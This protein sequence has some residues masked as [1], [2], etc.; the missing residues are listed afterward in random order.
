[1]S[2]LIGPGVSGECRIQCGMHINEDHFYPR[3]ST[4]KPCEARAGGRGGR[5]G[6]HHRS[7]K[8]A[9]PLL[10]YRTRDITRLIN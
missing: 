9:L 2:E 5:A 4:P 7:P 1:M 6:G 10:R 3:S 8:Q